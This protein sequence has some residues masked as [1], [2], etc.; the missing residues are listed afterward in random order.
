MLLDMLGQI[1]ILCLDILGQILVLCLLL[2]LQDG[3]VMLIRYA[4]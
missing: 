4:S 3:L 1:L 2:R